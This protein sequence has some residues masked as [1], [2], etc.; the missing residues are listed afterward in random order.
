MNLFP[1]SEFTAALGKYFP[2]LIGQLAQK[3]SFP[4]PATARSL[5]NQTSRHDSRVVEH[6]QVAGIQELR[7]I[8]KYPMFDRLRRPANDEQSR[9]V[10]LR[11]RLLGD[12]FGR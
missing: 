6:E 1:G 12:E 5:S 2:R 8:F 4:T 11:A 10:P 7:Q 3:Q 9:S